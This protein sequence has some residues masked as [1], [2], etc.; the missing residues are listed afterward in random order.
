MPTLESSLFVPRPVDEVFAFFADA[1]NLETITPPWL[2]FRILTPGEIALRP[3]TTID[4][5]L[6][7]HG[8]P[9]RCRSEIVE[10]DPPRRFVDVQVRGPYR[11]W[12]HAHTFE[13]D[14]DG[15][16][17]RD[18]VDYAVPGGRLVDALFVRRDLERIFAFRH[19]AL[20]AIFGGAP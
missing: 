9:I 17:V 6:R 15:T 2:Q 8:V 3:G 12:E 14:G 10:F 18:R 5:R 7:L 19:R 16:R 1:R 11:R 4:Y 20:A 13:P